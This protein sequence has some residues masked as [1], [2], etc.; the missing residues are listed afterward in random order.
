MTADQSAL[1]TRRRQG[2]TSVLKSVRTAVMGTEIF[3][4]EAGSGPPVVLL[5]GLNDSHRTWRRIL[6]HLALSKRV[7]M[8]DLPGCGLSARPDACY[9]L[10][11]QAR[12]MSAWLGKLGIER[13]DLV[14]HS[15]GGGV[16]QYMLLVVP[17]RIRRLALVAA[18]GLGRE[19]S[20]E[21]RLAALP[22][23]V[24]WLGQPFMGPVAA[25]ALRRVGGLVDAE[26]ARWM[27][28]VNRQPGTARAFARTV[29]DVLSWRGQTRHFLDRARD[30]RALPP[31]QLFWGEADRVIPHAQALKTV[32]MLRGA[33]LTSFAGCGHFPQH[34]QPAALAA[35]LLEFFERPAI[36]PVLC[37]MTPPSVAQRI[38]NRVGAA[39]RR[40]VRPQLVGSK[41]I[42]QDWAQA[43]HAQAR[44]RELLSD[45]IGTAP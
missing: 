26:E 41:E 37:C 33:T 17:Q 18:G 1:G 35:E 11:W 7:L 23:V 21:L 25:H 20:F 27:R 34:Q 9:S 38:W 14:G 43:P 39:Y 12:V 5:H 30:I 45:A 28:E 29:R 19:V 8:P 36:P 4:E 3:H 22:W 2:Q 6:P 24:E 32:Q 15:Y 31:V 42:L 10:D 44:A 40:L 16:A 13:A